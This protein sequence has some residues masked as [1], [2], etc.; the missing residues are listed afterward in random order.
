MN[1]RPAYLFVVAG[2]LLL[3][4]LVPLTAW[5][6]T[7][8]WPPAYVAFAKENRLAAV[9]L[10]QLLLHF[11]PVSLVSLVFGAIVFGGLKEA[12]GRAV[13]WISASALLPLCLLQ[14]V[15]MRMHG[16]GWAAFADLVAN[17]I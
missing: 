1:R 16:S 9:W 14:L 5:L 12:S 2:L 10:S 4:L 15:L 13:A 6:A 7:W 8:V 3:L 17:P 11:L